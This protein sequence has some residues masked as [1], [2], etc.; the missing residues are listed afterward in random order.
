[1][2]NTLG[3][4]DRPEIRLVR[5]TL[6]GLERQLADGAYGAKREALVIAIDVCR[7]KLAALG[8]K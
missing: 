7:K 6:A 2:Q 5:S 4:A 8:A 1:M 3:L